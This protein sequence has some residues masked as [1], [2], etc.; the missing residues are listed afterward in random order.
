MCNTTAT[1]VVD[2]N[3]VIAEVEKLLRNVVGESVVLHPDLDP[4][5]GRIKADPRKID[6]VFLNLAINAHDDMS[7]RSDLH[8]ETRNVELERDEASEMEVQPGAYVQ[9]EITSRL[10]ERPYPHPK[11]AEVI[12]QSQGGLAVRRI[13]DYTVVT[14]VLPRLALT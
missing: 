12:R 10:A 1:R 5:L 4:Q 13:R 8:I 9:V 14:F 11:V 6:W 2:L 3:S 7:G